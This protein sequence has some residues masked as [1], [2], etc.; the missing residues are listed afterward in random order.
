[1]NIGYDCIPVMQECYNTLY[2]DLSKQLFFARMAVD[3]D[4][5]EQHVEQ[6]AALSGHGRKHLL[7][8]MPWLLKLAEDQTPIYL[9]GAGLFGEW[10]R[11]ILLELHVNVKGFLD[12]RYKTLK[13]CL[14]LP[15]L[16]PPIFNKNWK[17]TLEC[18]AKIL[19]TATLAEDQVMS[20]LDEADVPK[21]KILPRT[22]SFA[23]DIEHQ[24]FD[25]LEHIPEKGAFVDGGCFNL[26]TS[27]RFANLRGDLSTRIIA[28]EP[29]PKS[30]VTCKEKISAYHLT[31]V[32]LVQAGLWSES[33]T[34][35]F[36]GE[37]LG[38]SSLTTEGGISVPVVTLD[39]IVQNEKVAFIKMDIEGSELAAL[40]GAVNTIRRDKP[41][42]AICIYHKPGDML[43][44]SHILKQLVPDYKF[45]IRHYSA[46]VY[47]TVLYAFV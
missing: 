27:I 7:E 11:K 34:L 44:I 23:V 32:K 41:F 20:L 39:E 33:T 6:L 2:D 45:A 8:Q 37:G 40:Q 25:F 15:V 21:E 29:D 31:N 24:Y 26:D 46:T 14:G 43:A 17:E 47:E 4:P 1:M 22:R 36:R 18:N 13:T 9:Y 10:W 16:P 38:T 35:R 42:C 30:Q 12:Q 19:I 5:S 28:F 3:I